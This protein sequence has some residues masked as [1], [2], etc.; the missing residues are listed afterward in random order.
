MI[1]EQ[2]Y[3]SSG[4]VLAGFRNPTRQRG[5]NRGYGHQRVARSRSGL[6]SRQKQQSA[7]RR[8]AWCS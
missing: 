5:L 1:I 4:M 3:V 8:G 6:P 7:C 2:T